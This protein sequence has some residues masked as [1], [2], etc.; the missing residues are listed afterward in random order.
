MSQ[1]K[2][3]AIRRLKATA[4]YT[5][6][7]LVAAIDFVNAE[8]E[9]PVSRP[10]EA[11]AISTLNREDWRAQNPILRHLERLSPAQVFDEDV[12]IV[13]RLLNKDGGFSCE[14]IDEDAGKY[15][16]KTKFIHTKNPQSIVKQLHKYG[17]RWVTVQHIEAAQRAR[18]ESR[19]HRF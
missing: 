1:R 15:D 17:Y 3:K 6:G 14:V 7:R 10:T 2:E 19:R 9:Y 18:H 8:Q 4:P 12:K 5:R 11:Q 16:P 13:I